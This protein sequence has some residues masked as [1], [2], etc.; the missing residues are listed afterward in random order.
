MVLGTGERILGRREAEEELYAN[1]FT[2]F[3]IQEGMSTFRIVKTPQGI[4]KVREG[5]KYDEQNCFES[6]I[7]KID[8]LIWL[9]IVYFFK[10]MAKGR[11]EAFVNLWWDMERKRYILSV[12]TQFCGTVR[13]HVKY[14]SEFRSY[15]ERYLLVAD[16]HSHHVMEPVFSP[17]DDRDEQGERLYGVWGGYDPDTED[18]RFTFRYGCDGMYIPVEAED[19]L[20]SYSPD[21]KQDFIPYMCYEGMFAGVHREGEMA[22]YWDIVG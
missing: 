20:D 2:R 11:N 12:P 17:V 19:V 5:K 22:K 4:F 21:T 13:C 15:S 8:R 1:D 6:L 14:D 9:R 7:P 3:W 16:I 18:Y 10:H